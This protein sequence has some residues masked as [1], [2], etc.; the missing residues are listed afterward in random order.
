[1]ILRNS[2]ILFI[3]L[4]LSFDPCEFLAI[5]KETDFVIDDVI[6]KLAEKVNSYQVLKARNYTPPFSWAEKL[7]LFK[8]EIRLNFF[9]PPISRDFRNGEASSV[10]DNDMFSSGW[11]LTALLEANLYGKGAPSL[12]KERLQLALD[13]IQ[14]F[15][16]KNEPNSEHSLIRT[17]WPQIF[18]ESNQLWFEQPINIRNVAMT[19]NKIPFDEIAKILEK[20]KLEKLAEII[21]QFKRF[22]SLSDVF[23]IPPDF[24]D[25]YLNLGLGATLSELSSKYPESAAAWLANNTDVSRLIDATCKYAFE[26]F[27]SDDL[28]KNL[29][30]PRTFYY[31][32]KFIQSAFQNEQDIKLVTTW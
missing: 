16:N 4:G 20:L 12:S 6:Q 2:L 3:L 21:E 30:D 15:N 22:G 7:G 25:T 29:I 31:A 5:K 32:R 23:S 9:G 24:D 11:I 14:A 17:F 28:N 8:S 1:M 19:L 13:A 27:N 26:P 18:N 10:F